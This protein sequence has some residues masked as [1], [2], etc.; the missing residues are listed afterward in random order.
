MTV[1]AGLT[2]LFGRCARGR[3]TWR[4]RLQVALTTANAG[5]VRESA[6]RAG[7]TV[8]RAGKLLRLISYLSLAVLN[9]SSKREGPGLWVT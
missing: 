1:L 6:S 7:N 5:N 3:H 4:K 9:M 8:G 2:L